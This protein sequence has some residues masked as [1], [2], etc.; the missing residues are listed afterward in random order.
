MG[1]SW[2]TQDFLNASWTASMP[3]GAMIGSFI[4]G[5]LGNK[6]GRRKA[7]MIFDLL[8]I[9]GCYICLINNYFPILFGRF[10]I[11]IAGFLITLLIFFNFII[12]LCF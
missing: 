10:I 1:N 12:K 3:L 2:I 4:A 9:L 7:L 5:D 6:H 8:I 11:G